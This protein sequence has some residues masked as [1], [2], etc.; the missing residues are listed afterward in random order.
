MIALYEI[1]Y[2]KYN[3]KHNLTYLD[4]KVYDKYIS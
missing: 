4:M 2:L 3:K 1:P